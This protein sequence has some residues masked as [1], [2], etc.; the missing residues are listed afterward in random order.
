VVDVA[1]V[2]F[3]ERMPLLTAREADELDR[4]AEQRPGHVAAKL[5]RLGRIILDQRVEMLGTVH[6]VDVVELVKLEVVEMVADVEVRGIA[7]AFVERPARRDERR[8]VVRDVDLATR[9]DELTGHRVSHRVGTFFGQIL[10]CRVAGDVERGR[11]AADADRTV[12]SRR[13]RAREVPLGSDR[14]VPGNGSAA[15]GE[16]KIRDLRFA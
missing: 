14:H 8:V 6:R 13:D 10:K 12:C 9:F 16:D 2:I 1:N 11:A 15:F 7:R 5:E 3:V 4:S